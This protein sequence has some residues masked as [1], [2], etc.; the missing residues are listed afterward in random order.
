MKSMEGITI[1]IY[2]ILREKLGSGISRY[3][4]QQQNHM[5][6]RRVSLEI[7]VKD[8]M[9]KIV[10]WYDNEAGYSKRLA[11]FAVKTLRT[12]QKGDITIISNGSNIKVQ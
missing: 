8:N 2:S 5:I 6:L 12:D 3:W 10:G 4:C 1:Y 9:I 11:D 7:M